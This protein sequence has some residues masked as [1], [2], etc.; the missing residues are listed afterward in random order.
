MPTSSRRKL[1][2]SDNLN[3]YIFL[4]CYAPPSL[5]AILVPCA[6]CLAAPEAVGSIS[7][8]DFD[9][10]LGITSLLRGPRSVGKDESFKF[11]HRRC[12]GGL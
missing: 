6:L 9:P 2:Y 10:F 4:L 7:R 5:H 8:G 1:L 11:E 3:P 12:V